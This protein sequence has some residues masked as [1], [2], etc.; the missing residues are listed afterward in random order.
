V[1]ESHTTYEYS[2][3]CTDTKNHKIH[4]VHIYFF[5][6][7][8]KIL[9]RER[10]RERFPYI[11]IIKEKNVIYISLYKLDMRYECTD[12]KNHKIHTVHILPDHT[13]N[14]NITERER[15]RER[16]STILKRR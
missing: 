10:E 15:E 16:L 2:Y 13:Q 12:T 1:I 6:Q 4:T 14:Q 3:E 7:R 8:I 9:Q 11:Y 5:T